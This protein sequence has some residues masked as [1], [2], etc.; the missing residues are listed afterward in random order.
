MLFFC[1][2]KGT[3]IIYFIEVK[4]LDVLKLLPQ[5]LADYIDSCDYKD[6][7]TEIKLRKNSIVQFTVYGKLK[8][9]PVQI[10]ETEIEDIFYKMCNCSVN[11][12]DDEISNGFITLSGGC[13]V[14]IGGE[15]FQNKQSGSYRLK[16]LKSLNIRIPHK[17]VC[18]KNQDILFAENVHSTLIAGLPHSGKT[19]LLK[20]YA[21]KLSENYRVS[22]CDERKEL[23]TDNLNVDVIQGIKKSAAISMATRTLNPQYIIC[24]EIGGKEETD[25][26][27]SAVNTGVYFICSAHCESLDQLYK[28]PNI[29]ILIENGIFEKLVLIEHKNIE[30]Y[31]KDIAYV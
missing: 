14:G 23:Y 13:R 8:N 19:S 16:E 4:I 18:F 11:I 20:I 30:F 25:E 29:K 22:L 7:I 21:E 28:R 27:L 5:R 10:S 3:G 15:Y 6:N 2:I 26:I 1:S 17:S 9:T 24:D 31:I 12:Y